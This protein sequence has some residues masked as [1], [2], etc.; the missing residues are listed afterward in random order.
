MVD[1]LEPSTQ[2]YLFQDHPHVE[3]QF[4]DAQKSM[5]LHRKDQESDLQL[6]NMA[7]TRRGSEIHDTYQFGVLD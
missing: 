3:V 6:Q 1:G 2:A 4:Q 5:L 7:C